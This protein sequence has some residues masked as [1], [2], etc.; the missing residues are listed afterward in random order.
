MVLTDTDACVKAGTHKAGELLTSTLKPEHLPVFDCAFKPARGSRSLH[1]TAHL[2]IM[3]AAQPFLSGAISKTV[4]V[5]NTIT[6]EEIKNIYIEAWQMGLKCVAIYRDGSK[7]SQP[8]NTSKKSD[9]EAVTLKKTVENLQAELQALRLLVGQPVRRRMADTRTSITHKFEIAGHEGYFTI[10]LFEDGTPGEMFITMS[11]EGSTIGGLMD[12][13]ATLTSVSLQ[14]GVPL[15]DLI[16]KFAHQRFEPS[17]YTKNP[18]IRMATSLVDYIF[19]WL[20]IHFIP[21]FM[22]PMPTE[23]TQSNT[24]LP[25]PIKVTPVKSGNNPARSTETSAISAS[26]SHFQMD[27][28]YCS[29]CGSRMVRSGACFK[30]QNCG[31]SSGCS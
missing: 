6:V 29:E 14:Y 4:N 3:G 12:T 9:E 5:P 31:S 27:A 10:G 30:C 17:G 7:M 22:E 2:K 24:S 26:M 25:A 15:Q 8:L 20:G 19:R 1:Y 23:N 11:K 13:I 28:P 18:Q 16:R 21:G